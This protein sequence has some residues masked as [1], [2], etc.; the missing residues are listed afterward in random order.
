MKEH[1]KRGG[2]DDTFLDNLNIKYNIG[3]YGKVIYSWIGRP[4]RIHKKIICRE[5]ER[6]TM[7]LNIL[8]KSSQQGTS[9]GGVQ[10]SY[11]HFLESYS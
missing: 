11:F 5:T 10:K 9:N 1:D 4:V 8:M 6:A 3:L 7:D 2:A